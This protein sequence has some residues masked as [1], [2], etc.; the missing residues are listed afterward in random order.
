[1][2]G[3][4]A[5]RSQMTKYRLHIEC[6]TTCVSLA[7]GDNNLVCSIMSK[8]GR[9]NVV[10]YLLQL[11]AVGVIR[12]NTECRANMSE[13]RFVNTIIQ[14][15]ANKYK[16]STNC[17]D[18]CQSRRQPMYPLQTHYILSLLRRTEFLFYSN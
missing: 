14:S 7:D 3:L 15:Y 16:G 4:F 13:D 11:R 18:V 9:T 8:D 2:L 6:P 17:C 1:M 12:L 5:S 10:V